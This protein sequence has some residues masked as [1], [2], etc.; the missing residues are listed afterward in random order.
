MV[1][2]SVP[3]AGRYWLLAQPTGA[4]I[5]AIGAL[6]VAGIGHAIVNEIDETGYFLASLGETA[7]RLGVP[8]AEAERILHDVLVRV[9]RSD[10]S[11]HL[12]PQPVIHY[13]HVALFD[14]HADSAAKYLTV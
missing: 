14:G 2:F 13:A 1:R 3:K 5:Q 7:Q 10:T 8:L 9:A 11:G 6:V 4:K 12:P